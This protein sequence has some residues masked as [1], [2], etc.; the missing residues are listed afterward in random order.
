MITTDF[1]NETLDMLFRGINHMP[2]NL[3]IALS[4]TDPANSVSEPIDISYSRATVP[5]T[6]E[7]WSAPANSEIYNI[8]NIDFINA[9]ND[10]NTESNPFRYWAI[11]DSLTGGKL[12]IY[13]SL[14]D[15]VVIKQ[16][17][18]FEL[19]IGTVKTKIRN[20]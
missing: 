16:L 10:W 1:S 15:P 17:Y 3:Y 4:T 2:T 6:S 8:K 19:P 12:K 20:L 7:Y 14:I 9:Q 13:G 11:F 5:C 18:T